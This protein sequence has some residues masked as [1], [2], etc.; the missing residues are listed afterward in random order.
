MSLGKG[1]LEQFL[2]TYTEADSGIFRYIFLYMKKVKQSHL[3]AWRPTGF[4]EVE[5]PRFLDGRHMKVVGCQP[6]TLA[7]F[8]PR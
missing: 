5:A 3:R 1:R 4:K 7:A 8:T 6:Y 2:H